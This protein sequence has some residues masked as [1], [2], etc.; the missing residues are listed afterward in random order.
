MR[1]E[2]GRHDAAGAE[3]VLQA[4]VLVVDVAQRADLA[5]QHRAF[6]ADRGR[7]LGREVARDAARHDVVHRE[8]VAEQ[9]EVRAQHVLLQARELRE[10]ER[11]AAVVAEIAE[12]AQVVGDALALERERA[13]P[14]RRAAAR[15]ASAIAS[16]ACAYAHA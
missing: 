11:E 3:A 6:V 14:Q 5:L 10:A 4:V 9:R 12:V 7:G 8:P 2:R 15:V 1:R 13:Q 16:S